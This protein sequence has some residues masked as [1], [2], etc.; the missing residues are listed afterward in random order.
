MHSITICAR[1]EAL[2]ASFD[3]SWQDRQLEEYTVSISNPI[4]NT[5][6]DDEYPEDIEDENFDGFCDNC[7][8]WIDDR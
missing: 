1:C 4:I 5:N 6:E 7:Q 3:C 8:D 2:S